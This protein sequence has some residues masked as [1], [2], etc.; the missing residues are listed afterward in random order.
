MGCEVQ[1]FAPSRMRM[2]WQSAGLLPPVARNSLQAH[3][4]LTSVRSMDLQACRRGVGAACKP[5]MPLCMHSTC[6]DFSPST[7]RGTGRPCL[8]RQHVHM[9]QLSSP[10]QVMLEVLSLQGAGSADLSGLMLMEWMP[11]LP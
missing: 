3:P 2:I 8:M 11:Q 10:L 4:A 1:A 9:V 7:M 5:K 6:L